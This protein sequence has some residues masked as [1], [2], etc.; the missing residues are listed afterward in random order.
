MNRRGYDGAPKPATAAGRYIAT[1]SSQPVHSRLVGSSQ[2]RK[3]APAR[4]PVSAGVRTTGSVHSHG[5]SG[6]G[7]RGLAAAG[8][9]RTGITRPASAGLGRA[10]TSWSQ[11][12]AHQGATDQRTQA[13]ELRWAGPHLRSYGMPTGTSGGSGGVNIVNHFGRNISADSSASKKL[14]QQRGVWILP[15]NGSA[16]SNAAAGAATPGAQMQ[17]DSINVQGASSGPRHGFHGKF[18]GTGSTTQRRSDML[19]NAQAARQQQQ[20][21]P[22]QQHLLHQRRLESTQGP[23][24]AVRP[25]PATTVED[26]SSSARTNTDVPAPASGNATAPSSD[27]KSSS[28]SDSDEIVIHVHDDR[29]GSS[30]DFH[31]TRTEIVQHMKYFERFLVRRKTG[32]EHMEEEEVDISVHCDISV[33]EWL[34]GF[35]RKPHDS[36]LTVPSVVSILISS[37]FLQMRPLVDLSL[38]FMHRNL[39]PI[40]KLPIDFSCINDQLLSQLASRISVDEL[41]QVQDSRDKL[42]GR[43]YMKKLESWLAGADG[44]M[45]QLQQC[46]H[47]KRCFT[48]AQHEWMVCTQAKMI[49]GY[50][51]TVV[52]R[53][54]ANPD[55][56]VEKY[57]LRLR[58]QLL[59]WKAIYWRLWGMANDLV[60]SFCEQ[61][62]TCQEIGH[63]AYHPS[64]PS[65]SD[66]S[67]N[68]G[69]LPCC[70][71]TVLRFDV[72]NKSAG[73]RQGCCARD[74]IISD[75]DK[76]GQVVLQTLLKRRELVAVPFETSYQLSDT[77]VE[78]KSTESSDGSGQPGTAGHSA[79]VVDEDNSNDSSS[80]CS[81]DEDEDEDDNFALSDDF[82]VAGNGATLRQTRFTVGSGAGGVFGGVAGSKHPTR[83]P[84]YL[85][86][87]EQEEKLIQ[88]HAQ[89]TRQIPRDCNPVRSGDRLYFI[90]TL[91]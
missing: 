31:C 67:G 62:F 74:H 91:L 22:S 25:A 47:C 39:S 26:R 78:L 38:D 18:S 17:T 59:S 5:L 28:N 85:A 61:R 34:V 48:P 68:A 83:Q 19:S 52:A 37:D 75:D 40:V 46:L 30:R 69:T 15:N 76:T 43:V 58:S 66:S 32:P 65:F 70:G 16:T 64:K 55:W 35:M 13:S 10:A 56:T 27:E 73:A 63:C 60:C 77:D 90:Q 44:D 4:R 84:R 81:S 8:V 71:Q 45:V 1:L 42:I 57:I 20:S 72:S 86:A 3:T 80:E 89:Q 33:F 12:Q 23:P 87:K 41:D 79:E 51:G 24:N 88:R 29:V 53:H 2:A 36:V 7:E 49:I 21:S 54:Q 14:S 82:A 6:A 50:H 11:Q 9:S